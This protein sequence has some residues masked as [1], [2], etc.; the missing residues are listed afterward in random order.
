MNA[1]TDTFYRYLT[2][3]LTHVLIT[4]SCVLLVKKYQAWK[5]NST[6]FR[7][8]KR[9][10]WN[11]RNFMKWKI[12]HPMW[13]SNQRPDCSKLQSVSPHPRVSRPGFIIGMSA[14]NERR[15]YS[16]TSSLFGCAHIQNNPCTLGFPLLNY[17]IA[18]LSE[19]P[20]SSFSNQVPP[21]PPRRLPHIHLAGHPSGRP[22]PFRRA[23]GVQTVIPGLHRTQSNL[24]G[25][26]PRQPQPQP[27]APARHCR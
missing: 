7:Q 4:T 18:Q 10:S 2:S 13:D 5:G 9:C 19:H 1:L 6:H 12:A 24:H 3:L 14:A 25:D 16:V 20:F 8:R 22:G 17:G 26:P 27:H 15:R 11:N 23:L 21:V